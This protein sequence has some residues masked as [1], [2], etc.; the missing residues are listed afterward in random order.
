[1]AIDNLQYN[2]SS[3]FGGSKAFKMLSSLK[4]GIMIKYKLFNLN[5]VNFCARISLNS[6]SFEGKEENSWKAML[7]AMNK[8]V[9]FVLKYKGPLFRN[10]D[11]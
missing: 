8:S 3:S 2:T 7:P 5:L 1:V 6:L 9:A 10:L 11:L 4:N